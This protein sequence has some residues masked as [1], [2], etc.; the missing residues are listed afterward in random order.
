MQEQ[1][2]PPWQLARSLSG[3]VAAATSKRRATGRRFGL[4]L[5]NVDDRQLEASSHGST[6]DSWPASIGCPAQIRI[7]RR[8]Q[9]C[10]I[11]LGVH[12]QKLQR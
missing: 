10:A 6:A 2:G 12:Q 4:W 8:R 9:S 1:Q 5:W 3:G 11:F 7:T